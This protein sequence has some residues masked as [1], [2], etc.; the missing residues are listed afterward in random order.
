MILQVALPETLPQP[1]QFRLRCGYPSA[2]PAFPGIGFLNN[3]EY[4]GEG[5]VA[6]PHHAEPNGEEGEIL[7]GIRVQPPD[8]RTVLLPKPR[9][10]P[11]HD[12]RIETGQIGQNLPEVPVIRTLQLVLDEHPVTGPGPF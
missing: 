4:W 2:Q 9:R 1:G 10:D 11:N 6:D 5:A 8:G 3:L 7:G 12:L